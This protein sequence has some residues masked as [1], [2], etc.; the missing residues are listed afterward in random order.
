MNDDEN[1]FIDN[2]GI[3]KNKEYCYQVV[4]YKSN[5]KS[6]SNNFCIISN[7][8]Y[9]PIQIPNAFTT[10]GDGLNDFF[11]P[12][13]LQ[14]SDYKMLIFNKYGEKVFESN[15]INLG[16][17]GYFKGKIIQDVYVYKIELMKDNEMVFINGK[18]LLVK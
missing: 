8:N 10:N 13:P 1:K 9:N 6:L 5:K 17:D 14:V 15:D 2:N 4:G 12:F 18:I 16:W 7:N 3:I 11:K